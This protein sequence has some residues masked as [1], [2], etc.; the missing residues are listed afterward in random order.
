VQIYQITSSHCARSGFS[1]NQTPSAA[2]WEC[3]T[4]IIAWVRVRILIARQA[5]INSEKNNIAAWRE[6]ERAIKWC[7]FFCCISTRDAL[8]SWRCA[9]SH[10][11]LFRTRERHSR[12]ESQHHDKHLGFQLFEQLRK[13]AAIRWSTSMET[14]C[15][16]SAPINLKMLLLFMILILVF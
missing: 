5:I 13:Q 4:L 8:Y 1:E 10:Y 2:R 6:S 14:I 12:N 16:T 7:A 15:H 9:I 3:E 11:V